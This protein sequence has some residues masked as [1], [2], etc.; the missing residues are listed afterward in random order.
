MDFANTCGLLTLC[1]A[2]A[3][4]DPPAADDVATAITAA[5]TVTTDTPTDPGAGSSG[6]AGTTTTTTTAGPATTTDGESGTASTGEVVDEAFLFD[7]TVLRTYELDVAPADWTWLNDNALLEQYVPA[8]LHFEGEVV[9]QAAV[10]YKGSVGSLKLCF[11]GMGNLICNK[12]S[13]K[14][15]FDEYDPEGR[16]HGLKTLNFH[17]MEKDPTR[18]HEAI[19]YK[20]FRDLGVP[21]PRTAYARVV[22]NGELIGLFAVIE[23]IDG[24]FTRERFP[25]GGE[26]NLYKEV[27]PVHAQ[28]QPYLD[29][30][31][32][33]KNEAPSADKIRRFADALKQAGDAGFADVI[34]AW[35]GADLL[36]RYMAVARL[37]DSWD[38]IVAWYCVKGQPCANHNYY[39]Y[40]ST[41][42][43]RLWL[44]AW[45]LDHSFEEPSPIRT[46]FGMPDWD[47]VNADCT[48]I[49]IFLG[50]QGRAP[51]C[52]DF[53][54]R[55][56]TQ[57]WDR[58]V[59]ESQ[60]LLAG[61]FSIAAM[62]TRIDALA[63][64]VDDAVAEDP[65]GVTVPE[66]QAAVKN[67]RTTVIAKR[68]H[69]ASKL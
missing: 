35:I 62:N 8:T 25:D 13:I 1:A 42:E 65:H 45:D 24:R 57:L 47:D 17:A 41:A 69:V 2:L 31:E 30:L 11:D 23:Q 67:L 48:P 6:D 28:E 5:S 7:E 58:Y 10:R 36:M 16:F 27:W 15:A 38:D 14:L 52:D 68:D 63:A 12:L 50:I 56:S 40:E 4:A 26:G 43:D 46:T 66:W 19:G 22:V 49:D 53:I 61:D 21:A 9:D 60:A 34:E 29:A 37:V 59:T 55:M 64:I 20:L 3:C 33:N 32:T 44:I 51:A 39:W 54:R 18:M